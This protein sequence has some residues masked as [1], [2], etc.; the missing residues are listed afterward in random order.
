MDRYTPPVR[1]QCGSTLPASSSVATVQT[2]INNCSSGGGKGYVLIGPGTF[3]VNSNL[4][5]NP[6]GTGNN[7]VELRGSGPMQATMQM[8][9]DGQ[10]TFG[11]INNIVSQAIT[12][13]PAQGSTTVTIATNGSPG[14]SVG[15][16]A[17]ISQ[18]AN[19]VSGSGC[20]TGVPYD[21]GGDFN[22]GENV[23][24]Q[25]Y[26]G[27]G[28]SSGAGGILQVVRVTNVSPS[29]C[30]TNCVIT[31]T[32]PLVDSAWSTANSPQI[33]WY[34]PSTLGHAMYGDGI[35]GFT[36]DFSQST[37]SPAGHQ[38]EFQNCYGCY[39]YGNRIIGN[40]VV[41]GSSTVTQ[42][43][44]ANVLM[45]S[46][47]GNN[48]IV[49]DWPPANVNHESVIS[50]I[51][52]H[53]GLSMDFN[54]IMEGHI[55][56]EGF[57][58]MTGH[59]IAYNYFSHTHTA[60][61]EGSFNHVV[62]GR[63]LL[64]EGNQGIRFDEDGAHAIH[65]MNLWFRNYQVGYDPP[66]VSTGPGCFDLASGRVENLIGN[67]CGNP[68]T[69]SSTKISTYRTDTST[70]CSPN[71]N[72]V[73]LLGCVNQTGGEIAPVDTL[74]TPTSMFW[75]NVTNITQ[76]SDTPANSGIRF[77]SSEV[78]STLPAYA[79]T[80]TQIGTGNGSTTSFSGTVASGGL[81]CIYGN[82]TVVAEPTQAVNDPG[83]NGSLSGTGSSSGSINCTTGA[84]SVTF[85]SA[86]AN[87]TAI[88]V[89]TVKNVGGSS[90]FQNPVPS[91]QTLPKSYFHNSGT[92]PPF[93]KV[94]TSF[95]TFP[96][97]TGTTTQP[98]PY[99]GPDVTGGPYVNG[100]AYD[101]PARVAYAN[102][103]VDTNYQF[104]YSISGSSW[105]GGVETIT[106]SGLPTN[107]YFEG[108]FRF[109]GANSACIPTSGVSYTG[110][111]DNEILMT[112]S[113]ASSG[114]FTY[115][116]PI[117][118]GVSCTG[119]VLYPD[120]RQFDASIYSA[121]TGG[122]VTLIPYSYNFGSVNVG[123]NSGPTTFT[124]TN[125]SSASATSLSATITGTNSG[126]F[127]IS[128]NTCTG[129]LANG[130]ATCTLNVTF[131]PGAAGSR[132]ASL[133]ISYSG[134]DGASPQTS[135]LSGTGVGVS[136]S[137]KVLGTVQV[138]GTVVVE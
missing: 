23:I 29:N 31:F 21:N 136:I 1:T 33:T 116:L 74:A 8:I 103:P 12:S 102:L 92:P 15:M 76:G 127:S 99:A 40:N 78:P 120:V 68:T 77:V 91:S 133:S 34:A 56:W 2:A 67:V 62:G 80:Q 119:S 123:G 5:F 98:W 55:Q 69:S 94:C 125:N 108:G 131:T 109:S 72:Y 138:E 104:T 14:I 84:V 54:N 48:Y 38:L 88:M 3:T 107:N 112:T 43:I 63:Y 130:G 105:A 73:Y 87:G 96:T 115:S 36:L 6:F 7:Y 53:A 25:I 111:S 95:S 89:N 122:S 37:L 18:C 27:E 129:T 19:G 93:W 106:I 71:T 85:Q 9:G 97:C 134:G 132:S 121:S 16:I 45:N 35:T 79:G 11:A 61:Y 110:R 24:C 113:N 47:I 41:S 70:G 22:C 44:Y 75:G 83:L 118:P 28:L 114:Q 57:G 39:I 135:T 124:L 51:Q 32:P 100:H 20:T 137:H 66:Y 42:N 82:E 10:I 126:D 30:T 46:I 59:V 49:P 128:S 52:Q 4:S 26:P 58:H 60:Y 13:T 64:Y 101:N 81:P 90:F 65:T 17:E 50:E 86:P 117:N